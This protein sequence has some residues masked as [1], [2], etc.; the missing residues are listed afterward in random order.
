LAGAVAAQPPSGPASAPTIAAGVLAGAPADIGAA[1]TLFGR[2]GVYTYVPDSGQAPIIDTAVNRAVARMFPLVRG[3]ARQR[4]MRTNALP[5]TLR[6]LIAPDTLGTQVR[7]E[8]PMILPRSGATV[9]WDDG[10]GNVCR[11]RDSVAADTLFQFCRIGTAISV[12]RYIVGVDGRRLRL[13]M[14][15]TSPHLSRPVEYSIEFGQLQ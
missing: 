1:A 6:L 4:L 3:I 15:V 5:D 9:R 12:A 2:P 7:R 13:M 11:A 8:K 10:R 14:V